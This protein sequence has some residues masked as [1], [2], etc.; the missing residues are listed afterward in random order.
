MQLT[1]DRYASDVRREPV[2]VAG[3]ELDEVGLVGLCPG[4]GLSPGESRLHH[5]YAKG[6]DVDVER[7][8]DHV[9]VQHVRCRTRL[10]KQ[11]A[12]VRTAGV[13]RRSLVKERTAE[14]VAGSPI[15]HGRSSVRMEW[16]HVPIEPHC[17]TTPRRLTVCRF[18][19]TADVR[20]HESAGKGQKVHPAVGRCP[21]LAEELIHPGMLAGHR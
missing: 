1:D 19:S 6:M 7:I 13:L 11:D 17:V 21:Y 16:R 9:H 15:E 8:V 14:L 10:Y 2:R 12:R 5:L 4:D 20:D 3:H 18:Q